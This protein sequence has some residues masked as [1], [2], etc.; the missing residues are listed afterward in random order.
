ME[1]EERGELVADP[2]F[3]REARGIRK[4]LAVSVRVAPWVTE[5]LASGA[6]R[7]EARNRIAAE[8]I[9]PVVDTHADGGHRRTGAGRFLER[10]VREW[11]RLAA[12]SLGHQGM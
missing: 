2:H 7:G 1:V 6:S 5:V 3:H 8:R 4:R 9:L 10:R 12:G 11:T